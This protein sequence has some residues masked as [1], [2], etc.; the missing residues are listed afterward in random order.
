MKK[1]LTIILC[2][3]FSYSFGQT[4]KA[5]TSTSSSAQVT[6]NKTGTD[7]AIKAQATTQAEVDAKQNAVINALP[8]IS[9]GDFVTVNGILYVDWATVNKRID[10]SNA[11]ANKRIDSTILVVATLNKIMYNNSVVMNN[12][13]SATDQRLA[14]MDAIMAGYVELFKYYDKQIAD[15][16]KSIPIITYPQ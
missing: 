3:A 13:I 4:F 12:Y 1:I 2:I 16:R 6:Y 15:L 11:A 9:K 8:L 14:K 5:A 10:S 7:N